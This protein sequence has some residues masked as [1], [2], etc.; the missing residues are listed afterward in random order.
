VAAQAC[1]ARIVK[2]FMSDHDIIQF[3]YIILPLKAQFEV[4]QKYD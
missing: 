4:L 3:I 2:P 1:E